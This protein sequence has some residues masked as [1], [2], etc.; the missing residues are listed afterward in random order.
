MH[1]PCGRRHKY[2]WPVLSCL[3]ISMFLVSMAWSLLPGHCPRVPAPAGVSLESGV[4]CNV[5]WTCNVQLFNEIDTSSWSYGVDAFPS[6]AIG[7]DGMLFV[8]F[9]DRLQFGVHDLLIANSSD[10]ET[11]STPRVVRSAYNINQHTSSLLV[12]GSGEVLVTYSYYDGSEDHVYFASSTGK[13][14]SFLP[15]ARVDPHAGFAVRPGIALNGSGLIVFYEFAGPVS[16]DIFLAA[17][18]DGG[19][20]FPLVENVTG[21][22]TVN[23]DGVKMFIDGDGTLHA[24]YNYG[25]LGS[26][27]SI[28]NETAG[29]WT[30]PQLVTVPLQGEIHNMPALASDAAG[31]VI[32]VFPGE[33]N[34][35][36]SVSTDGCA[37]WAA[38]VDVPGTAGYLNPSVAYDEAQQKLFIVAVDASVAGH[39]K[40]KYI[41]ANFKVVT[42]P[43][44][45]VQ[46]Q[47][48]SQGAA[49]ALGSYTWLDGVDV[50]RDGAWE[51]LAGSSDRF[52]RML[53][54]D[55]GN[56]TEW[57]SI[58]TGGSFPRAV[59]GFFDGDS[60]PDLAITSLGPGPDLAV[61]ERDGNGTWAERASFPPSGLEHGA[62]GLARHDIN[63]DGLVDVISP[64]KNATANGLHVHET[65]GND[66]YASRTIVHDGNSYLSTGIAAGDVDIIVGY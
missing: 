49:L 45:H 21:T 3:I 11:F 20:S 53:E 41:V 17:S 32:M 42:Y 48:E 12:N 52:A 37:S 46:V 51:L 15:E 31:N 59:A 55:R 22:A 29:T 40:Y 54:L 26:C 34:L 1:L 56:F 27:H 14:Q 43:D 58:D 35:R 13:G 50:D 23:E 39:W 16:R 47:L 7:A 61:L 19:C 24:L 64:F 33:G 2:C 28:R 60:L 30:P 6:V 5:D 8:T 44:T 4:Q 65:L 36:F 18:T 25:S 38:A 57:L 10:H 63:G 66:S 62:I 9:K